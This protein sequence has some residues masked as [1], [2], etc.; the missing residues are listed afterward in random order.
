VVRVTREDAGVSRDVATLMAGEF[1]G[2]MALLHGGARRATCRAV[3]P[4]ALYELRRADVDVV[5]EVCPEM[6][7]ALEEA[8]RIRSDELEA[9]SELS[10]DPV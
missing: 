1:F 5:R 6:Q 9:L 2:E 8:D 10:S 4:C 7:V 3:T